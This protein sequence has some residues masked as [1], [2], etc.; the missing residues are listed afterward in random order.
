MNGADLKIVTSYESNE[1]ND[2]I[3]DIEFN[4]AEV[5]RYDTSVIYVENGKNSIVSEAIMGDYDLEDNEVIL[6]QSIAKSLNLKVGDDIKF[7]KSTGIDE[8]YKVKEIDQCNSGV[9]SQGELIGYIKMKPSD[10]VIISNEKIILINDVDGDKVK[11]ELTDIEDGYEYTSL[12]DQEKKANDKID[13]QLMSLNILNTMGYI[14]TIALIV[15]TILLTLNTSKKDIAVLRMLSIDYKCIKRAMMLQFMLFIMIPLVL[16]AILSPFI[17][18]ILIKYQNITTD[19]IIDGHII[20]GI[21]EGVIFNAVSLFIITSISLKVLQ[22]IKPLDV[23]RTV[24][25]KSRG[26]N[27]KLFV[28]IAISIPIIL[29]LYSV[30]YASGKIFTSSIFIFVFLS[31]IFFIT[32]IMVKLITILPS[33]SSSTKYTLKSIRKTHLLY[34][35]VVI[36]TVILLICVLIGFKLGDILKNSINKGI[37]TT[38]PYNYMVKSNDM[39]DKYINDYINDNI[40]ML[41]GYDCVYKYSA[42]VEDNE[43]NQKAVSIVDIEESEKNLTFN[44]I[45]GEDLSKE[46]TNEVIVSNKYCDNNNLKVGDKLNI[47]SYNG[48]VEYVI[49][50]IYDC[51]SV[52]QNWILKYADDNIDSNM[53]L[54]KIDDNLF[55]NDIENCSIGNMNIVGDAV[56]YQMENFLVIFKYLCFLYIISGL[57]FSI[58]MTYVYYK[59]EERNYTIMRA[60]GKGKQFA[61]RDQ[62]LKSV[63]NVILSTL[64]SV[65]MYALII[66]FALVMMFNIKFD[67]NADLWLFALIISLIFNFMSLCIILRRIAC[68]VNF[69]VLRADV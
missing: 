43:V 37:D 34:L 21:I 54:L 57:V 15:S 1:F 67:V 62:I 46:D 30:V 7:D 44:I 40:D 5:T 12:A 65:G 11:D 10:K 14:L 3:N 53:Y 55:I 16:A 4:G 33:R 69:D 23:I 42:K 24:D 22:G 20:Q 27:V 56:Y 49:K 36:N 63:L 52:N 26:S 60:I 41:S 51:S 35:V 8:E 28:E 17:T 38:L 31:I 66:K 64:I 29:F 9:N 32:L 59:N 50:G 58:N 61:V 48:N 25:T 45:D 39:N 13:V 19:A 6:S 2:K 47:L 18:S 68:N